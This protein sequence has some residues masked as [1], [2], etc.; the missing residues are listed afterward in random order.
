M[1]ADDGHKVTPAS[2]Q[3]SLIKAAATWST[4]SVADT[5]GSR[6]SRSGDRSSELLLNGQAEALSENWSTPRATDGE[7]GGPNQAF[8]A[9]GTPLPAQASTWY[10]P[11]TQYDGRT[12]AA[13][14]KAREKAAAKHAAGDYAK[15]TG[16]PTMNDLQRQAI[17]QA[18]T[19]SSILPDHPISTVGEESSHIRR[20]LNPLFVEWL[21][22]WPPGWTSLALMPPASNAC[23]C[24][25]TELSRWK[26]RMRSALLSL[27][28]PPEAAP[29]QQSLFA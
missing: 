2:H 21:M 7:K 17:G 18:D 9:G 29:A 5:T 24:S 22:G 8:G 28:L 26:A 3:N 10:T 1:A 14:T 6:K 15:G 4:P 11:Q 25:E 19:L 23:A 16:A 13:V 27:G 20:T 12:E